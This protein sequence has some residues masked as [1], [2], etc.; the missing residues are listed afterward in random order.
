MGGGMQGDE[1]GYYWRKVALDGRGVFQDSR[2]R[3]NGDE[4]GRR[5]AAKRRRGMN[6][7]IVVDE[8]RRGESMEFPRGTGR[9]TSSVPKVGMRLH[10][11]RGTKCFTGDEVVGRTPDRYLHPIDEINNRSVGRWRM[12]K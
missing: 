3:E 10:D 5:V 2:G 8:C 4:E 9:G 11:P 7:G 12:E 1:S 6:I